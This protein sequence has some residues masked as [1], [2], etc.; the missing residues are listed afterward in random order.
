MP[1]KQPAGEI[2]KKAVDE[3]ISSRGYSD[4][5]K[6]IMLNKALN[7]IGLAMIGHI[8]QSSQQDIQKVK[9]II[10]E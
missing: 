5:E 1:N 3:I 6:G 4:E 9:D 8:S 10:E 7:L 2:I